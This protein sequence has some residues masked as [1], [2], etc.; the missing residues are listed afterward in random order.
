FYR[1]ST[2][3]DP[4][5]SVRSQQSDSNQR[6]FGAETLRF[7]C[8]RYKTSHH[9]LS[10]NTNRSTLRRSDSFHLCEA[11][12]F[13]ATAATQPTTSHSL[14][15]WLARLT[16]AGSTSVANSSW[17]YNLRHRLTCWFA[18]PRI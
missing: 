13:S 8:D 9:S 17:R 14:P 3:P 16:S 5:P 1:F 11:V 10:R 6:P 12:I 4:K 15:G 18:F 2:I 7:F